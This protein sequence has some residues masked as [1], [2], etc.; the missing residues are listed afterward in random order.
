MGR[1]PVAVVGGSTR[2]D[3]FGSWHEMTGGDRINEMAGMEERRE[4][5]VA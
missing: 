2:Y 5:G 3:K 1:Y 4:L